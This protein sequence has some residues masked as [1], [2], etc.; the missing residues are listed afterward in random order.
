VITELG[1]VQPLPLGRQNVVA[2]SPV[3]RIASLGIGSIR[4]EC[5]DHVIIRDT[6]GWNP[7][8]DCDLLPVGGRSGPGTRK[9][10]S[11][12]SGKLAVGSNEPDRGSGLG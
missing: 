11:N 12:V 10:M 4:R 6:P 2:A 1:S 8:R 9:T 3:L 5:L 7:G